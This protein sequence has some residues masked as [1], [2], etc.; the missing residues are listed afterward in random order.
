MNIPE[1]TINKMKDEHLYDNVHSFFVIA[2]EDVVS[3]LVRVTNAI[4]QQKFTTEKIESKE[5][6][7]NY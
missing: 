1:K 4:R 3:E 2:S 5:P 7:N 6:V